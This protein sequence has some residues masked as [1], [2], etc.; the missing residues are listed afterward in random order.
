MNADAPRVDLVQDTARWVAMARAQESERSD[1]L[2]K[3]PFARRLAGTVGADLVQKLSGRAG[4]TWP[5]VARTH[6]VDRLVSDAVREGADAMLNLAAGLDS[7]PYR[8]ELP[9]SFTW[10]EVD[11]ADVIA[12]KEASLRDSDPVCR[13]ERI[14]QDL[15]V[16]SERRALLEAIGSRFRHLV[17]MT[18]GLL[19][20]LAPQDAMDLARDIRAIPS[21]F[22]WIGDIN[23]K[24][25]NDF[26]ARRTR[27]ALQ[28]TAQMK[29]G[30]DD[31]PLVFEPLGWTTVSAVSIFKTAGKL[32]RLPFPMSLFARLPERPYGTPGRPWSGVC[33]WE[34]TS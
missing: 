12:E 20:Y 30:P 21:V 34:P 3:D 32:K 4:G 2:F 16:A 7:R 22:R 1:A 26:V 9:P 11:H 25:V 24:A 10:I 28:G 14:A 29:F 15:A 19:V 23:N 18:E 13:L 6:I 33:V 8:M 27:H 5:I 17:V 31:G